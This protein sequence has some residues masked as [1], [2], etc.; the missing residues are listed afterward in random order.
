MR[1]EKI[2]AKAIGQN[3]SLPC[4]GVVLQLF[5]GSLN[6]ALIAA[7]IPVER[8]S[9]VCISRQEVIEEV[10]R[11]I[12]RGQAVTDSEIDANPNLPASG[13]VRRM[14]ES[15]EEL[16]ELAGTQIE[17]KDFSAE[18][19]LKQYWQESK[20]AG[21]WLTNKEMR[22][23]SKL[24]SQGTYR[25]TF[26]NI[27]HLRECAQKAYGLP[28]SPDIEVA[29]TI[30]QRNRLAREYYEASV[31]RGRW[32]KRKEINRIEGLKGEK[33]YFRYFKG[34]ADLIN[35]AVQQCGTN[36]GLSAVKRQHKKRTSINTL[37]SLAKEYF[38]QSKRAGHWLT[39]QEIDKNEEL[40]NHHKCARI[41]GSVL[42]LRQLAAETY[43]DFK[44]NN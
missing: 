12:R 31:K 27:K 37:D 10:I 17:K 40:P 21:H 11:M 15:K 29:E 26:G 18:G 4:F 28:F 16:L 42:R 3:P 32:G 35:Y 41:C 14:F 7:D 30:Q 23:N 44:E 9:R 36:A 13:T 8:K 24:A 1:G 2:T 34:M 5:N 6:N 22:A 43:G 25:K 38:L 33:Q 20:K 19:M 39:T